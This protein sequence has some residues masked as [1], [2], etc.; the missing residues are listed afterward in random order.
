MAFKALGIIL[1]VSSRWA[2][3]LLVCMGVHICGCPIS[4][5]VRC[6]ET[7]VLAFMNNAL[8]L[9]SAADDITDLIICDMLSTAPLLMG[10]SSLPATN[11]CVCELDLQLG[12]AALITQCQLQGWLTHPPRLQ[13]H[14]PLDSAHQF[15]PGE[16]VSWWVSLGNVDRTVT[17]NS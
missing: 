13:H 2:V 12:W 9:A 6:M 10:M 11:T 17:A 7:A 3:E 8:S 1:L 4:L 16:N 5:R 14:T 15:P